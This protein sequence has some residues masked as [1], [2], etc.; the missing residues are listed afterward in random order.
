[1]SESQTERNQDATFF[2]EHVVYRDADF[3]LRPAQGPPADESRVA[4]VAGEGEI[5]KLYII[6]ICV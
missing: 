4:G 2:G 1:M 3:G 6:W 5:F